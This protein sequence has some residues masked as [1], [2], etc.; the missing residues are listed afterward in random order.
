MMI[1]VHA[2]TLDRRHSAAMER[3]HDQLISEMM[4]LFDEKLAAIAEA[5]GNAKHNIRLRRDIA[6][7]A[8]QLAR[9]RVA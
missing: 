9:L 2:G 1:P 6:D 7:Q 3:L 4:T 5:D 8:K